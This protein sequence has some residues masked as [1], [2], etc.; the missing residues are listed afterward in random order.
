MMMISRGLALLLSIGVLPVTVATEPFSGLKAELEERLQIELE[1]CP[2][3]M[4][5]P[6][7]LDYLLWCGNYN[8]KPKKFPSLW[9]KTIFRIQALQREEPDSGWTKLGDERKRFN[10]WYR[11]TPG[12]VLHYGDQGLIILG[13]DMGTLSCGEAGRGG[14]GENGRI[15]DFTTPGVVGPGRIYHIPPDYPL[16]ERQH[17]MHGDVVLEVIVTKKGTVNG[18]CVAEAKPDYAGFKKEAVEAVRKWRYKPAV[19]DG[20]PVD[21]HMRVEISFSI[22]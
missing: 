19:L 11:D 15:A 21:F 6:N 7:D 22:H 10:F 20:R 18:I 3:G 17:R 13:L 1:A 14:R 5:G 2:D 4:L 9:S 16:G 8:G 12:M